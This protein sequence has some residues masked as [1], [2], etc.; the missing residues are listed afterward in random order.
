[1]H[2]HHLIVLQNKAI[3]I[4]ND[5]PPRM[6]VD[7]LFVMQNISSV[8]RIYSYNVGLFTYKFSSRLL[9]DVFDNF[10][11]R[12]ADVHGYNTRNASTQHGD[13]RP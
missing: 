9:P 11:A 10:F 13:K 4:I 12:L 7:S 5:I 2:L 8:K 3:R 1:M 6:S